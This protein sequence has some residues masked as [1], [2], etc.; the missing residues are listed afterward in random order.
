MKY[1]LWYSPIE[2]TALLLQESD[3]SAR[4]AAHAGVSWR[5]EADTYQE[6]CAKRDE[7]LELLGA[8]FVVGSNT[9]TTRF[10]MA[11]Y[12]DESGEQRSLNAPGWVGMLQPLIDKRI[13]FSAILGQMYIERPGPHAPFEM[14]EFFRQGVALGVD[15]ITVVDLRS[16]DG[17]ERMCQEFFGKIEEHEPLVALI[18]LRLGAELSRWR[19]ADTVILRTGQRTHAVRSNDV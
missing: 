19:I 9:H 5:V 17:T 1:E 13:D 10:T 3:D 12:L 6:A 7:Y 16:I 14:A 4:S 18:G 11:V 2:K 8:D 15:A